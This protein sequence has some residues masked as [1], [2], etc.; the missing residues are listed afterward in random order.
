VLVPSTEANDQVDT[1]ASTNWRIDTSPAF[2]P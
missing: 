1:T 2:S